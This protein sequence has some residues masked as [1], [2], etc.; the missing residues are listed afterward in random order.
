MTGTLAISSEGLTKTYR[1]GGATLTVLDHADFAARSGEIALVMG[2]SGSGKSTLIAVLSGLLKPDAGSV[3]ALGVDLWRLK[4]AEIDRFR[5]DNCGFIFPGVQP[6]PGP[7]GAGAGLA[8]A[9]V[10][11]PKPAGSPPPGRG[12]PGRSGH[13][14]APGAAPG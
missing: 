8:G 11:R 9:E 3:N 1:S 13:D 10:R 7:D 14:P 6:V 4:P 12:R 5:L 2:P